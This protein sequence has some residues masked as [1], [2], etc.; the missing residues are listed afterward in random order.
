MIEGFLLSLGTAL[1]KAVSDVTQKRATLFINHDEII[2]LVQRLVEVLI[3]SVVLAALIFLALEVP[4]LAVSVP[5]FVATV[6]LA[7]AVNFLG[8][9]Y[10]VRALRLSD[11]SLVSPISQ[12]TPAI[13]LVTSPLMLGEAVSVYGVIG[14]LLVV[15]GAYFLGVTRTQFSW[16]ALGDPIRHL[17]DNRGVRY[18]LLASVLYAFS[19]NLDKIGIT[20]SDPFIY[21]VAS[22]STMAIGIALYTLFTNRSRL[23]VTASGV[24]TSAYSGVSGAI[25]SIFQMIAISIW[26]VPYVIAIKRLSSVVSVVSGVVLLKEKNAL[27]RLMGAA[28]MVV[29]T[30]VIVLWG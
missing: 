20:M 27:P 2:I 29:G 24:R 12:L 7:A 28:I 26:A 22:G 15:A 23:A 6:M 16:R 3:G 4:H 11:V 17:T 30:A 14:V 19:S 1:C 9:Y 5:V 25:G 10:N 21:I 13:L 8:F 18:A